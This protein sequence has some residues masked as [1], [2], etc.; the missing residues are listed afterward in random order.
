MNLSYGLDLLTLALQCTIDRNCLLTL[1]VKSI[2][3]S[4]PRAIV[5]KH[6]TRK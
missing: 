4:L 3:P 2:F 5:V 1:C 6:F